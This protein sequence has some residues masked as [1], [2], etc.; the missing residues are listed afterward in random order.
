M[1]VPIL[2]LLLLTGS[3]LRGAPFTMNGWQFHERDVSRLAEAINKAPEYGVN[4]LIFSHNLFD[5]VDPF[6]SSPER[7]RDVLYLGSLADRKKIAWYLWVHEFNDI[8]DRF[9]VKTKLNADDPRMS[10]VSATSSFHLAS[11]VNMDDPALL[12]YLRDRYEQLLAKCPTAAGIVLTLHESDSKLFRDSEVAS[13][14]PVPERI[15][16]ITKLVYDVAKKHNK[17]LILRNFFYEPKEMEYFAEAIKRLPD[18]IILMSKDTVHEFDPWYP[19]DPMHGQ[20]GK[21]HQ[22]MEPDLGVE[23]AWGR[24]GHYAQVAYIKRYVERARDTHMAGAVGRMHVFWDHPFE[25][26]HEINLYAF[27]RF[28]Q[29]PSL[30]VDTVIRDWAMR[31]YPE[32]AVP[33]IA[34]AMKRTE[35][36][37]HHGRWFLGFWLTK[38]LG[39]E[40]GDYPYYFGHILL[41]SR[42]KWTRDQADKDLEN[43][44]MS[45]DAALFAKLVGEKDEVIQQVR[46][47]IADMQNAARYMK[48]EQLK[49]LRDGFSY[50]L[51]AAELQREWT[52]AF[53]GFRMWV[54]EP[55]EQNAT[56]VNDALAK[57]EKMDAL[58][59]SYGKDLT[60]GHR[61]H[62]DQFVLEMH[63]RMA[64]RKRSLEEDARILENTRRLSEVEAN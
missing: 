14:L 24:E 55:N 61:Y 42:Y 59:V 19:P 34:S 12:D 22:L 36:I 26:S 50:L 11:R 6:L 57:L 28:M 45:P 23:K 32:E 4:F 40:W 56:I 47:S 48:P 60:T 7:Q 13:K 16:L 41:R 43:G 52:R 39:D 27:S 17:Q 29:D 64:N 30:D 38:S 44:L 63:W 54:K 51:D 31:R 25:D 15:Y 21:K 10:S 9:R 33:Y 58:P 5:R 2:T 37:Q 62:L 1:R 20:V 35:F 53:F 18:D 46:A 8:P 49:P 3:V